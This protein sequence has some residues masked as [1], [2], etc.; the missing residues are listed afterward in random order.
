[1]YFEIPLFELLNQY[2]IIVLFF[3]L[4]EHRMAEDESS[5]LKKM[6]KPDG[7]ATKPFIA[8]LQHA[9]TVV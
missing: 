1:M 2:V 9:E 3:Y 4:Q 8:Y 5:F 6:N 7:L